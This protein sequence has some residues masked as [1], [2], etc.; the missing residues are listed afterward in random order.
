MATKDILK[1]NMSAAVGGLD[2]FFSGENPQPPKVGN[3]KTPEKETPKDK[4]KLTRYNY[5]VTPEQKKRIKQ[6]SIDMD[7]TLKEILEAALTEYLDR[8]ERKQ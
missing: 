2:N 8:H 4:V 6:L 3:K 1:E 7:M 5:V